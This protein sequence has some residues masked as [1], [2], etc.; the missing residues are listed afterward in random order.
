MAPARRARDG[1]S[2]VAGMSRCHFNGTIIGAIAS[3][4][5][6]RQLFRLAESAKP[7][8]FGCVVTLPLDVQHATLFRNR[9]EA[10][11]LPAPNPPLLPRPAFCESNTLYSA[12]YGWRRTHLQKVQMWRHIVVEA[13]FDMLSVDANYE[14][15]S[16]PV[17]ALHSMPPQLAGPLDPAHA[18][19]RPVDVMGVHDGPQNKM[20]NIGLLWVRSTRQTR[21]LVIRTEN[22]TRAAWDQLVFNDE[23]NFNPSFEGIGC[24]VSILLKRAARPQVHGDAAQKTLSS[25][26]LRR[27]IEG[28]DRCSSD[29]PGAADAL[30]HSSLLVTR[31]WDPNAYNR[32]PGM[33]HRKAGRCTSLQP[34]TF[35]AGLTDWLTSTR[36]ANRTRGVAT[37]ELSQLEA[38]VRTTQES[39]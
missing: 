23:L 36:A 22:R 4:V 34:P 7:F 17:P 33:S 9:S 19:P 31:T 29:V 8:G 16:N 30:P 24:C 11:V 37:L 12:Q 27:R 39:I 35:C 20:I 18:R 5:Y 38:G 25:A 1:S 28:P 13:G 2:H 3:P 21:E 15:V 14:L 10:Y 32:A 26:A 6:V